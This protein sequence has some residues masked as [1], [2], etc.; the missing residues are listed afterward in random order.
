MVA[1]TELYFPVTVVHVCEQ[2]D[3]SRCM[4]CQTRELLITSR[5]HSLRNH[6][7]ITR[8]TLWA[9]KRCRMFN[10]TAVTLADHD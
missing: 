2:L 6:S 1:G 10:M 8:P 7:T 5:M 3:Q 4:K 9:R